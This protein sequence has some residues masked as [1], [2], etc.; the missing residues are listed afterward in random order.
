[1]GEHTPILPSALNHTRLLLGNSGRVV[2]MWELGDRVG[3][4]NEL[5]HIGAAWIWLTPDQ[6]SSICPYSGPNIEGLERPQFQLP[7]H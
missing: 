2:K 4:L 1:M 3:Y 6:L 5:H 7:D